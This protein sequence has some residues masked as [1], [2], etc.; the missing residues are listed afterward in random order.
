MPDEP[1]ISWPDLDK[2]TPLEAQEF[3]RKEIIKYVQSSP[4]VGKDWLWVIY[5]LILKYSGQA[6]K[7]LPLMAKSKLPPWLILLVKGVIWGIN[8]QAK[9]LK[10]D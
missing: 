4:G 2:I 3:K 5:G 1:T 8:W 7:L 6:D 9:R 10:I